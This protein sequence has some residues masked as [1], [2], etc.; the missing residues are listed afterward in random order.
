MFIYT[1]DLKTGLGFGQVNDVNVYKIILF[2]QWP[3]FFFTVED[4]VSTSET[5][6]HISCK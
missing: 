6:F 3:V 1:A 2:K 4:I 5:I